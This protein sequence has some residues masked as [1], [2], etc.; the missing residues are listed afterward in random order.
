APFDPATGEERVPLDWRQVELRRDGAN[1]N[2]VLGGQC[3]ADF[4][5]NESE[6]RDAWRI[7]QFYR[8]TEQVQVGT[9]AKP[10]SYYLVN[11]KA[12]HGLR[13]GMQNISFHPDR[14]AVRQVDG[15]WMLCEDGQRPILRGGD[16]AEEARQ[17]LQA[18]Q[19][20]KFDNYCRIGGSDKAGLSFMVR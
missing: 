9:S 16:S 6:A 12:P 19:K 14:L 5:P 3:L 20:Y 15:Q 11:G 13:F 17:V 18:I 7:F 1:W 4:G 2:L 8:F 10:F